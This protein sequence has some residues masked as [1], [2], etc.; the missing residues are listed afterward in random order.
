MQAGF[1]AI[2]SDWCRIAFQRAPA[3]L[4]VCDSATLRVLGANA[5]ASATYGYAPGEWP[6]TDLLSLFEPGDRE[7][8]RAAVAAAAHEGEAQLPALPHIGKDGAC[9]RCQLLCYR[10]DGDQPPPVLLAMQDHTEAEEAQAR[11]AHLQD[12]LWVSQEV[13]GLGCCTMNLTTARLTWSVQQYKNLGLEAASVMPSMERLLAPVHAEERPG[14]AQAIE[15]CI[16]NGAPF[17]TELHLTWPDG[18]EHVMRASGRRIAGD[19]Q[20]PD[21]F[22]CATLDITEQRQLRDRLLQTES[23]LQ[24]AQ[25]IAHIGTWAADLRT[26]LIETTSAETYR[27]F[28]IDPDSSGAPGPFT[29]DQLFRRIHPEDVPGVAAAREHTLHTPG[30][31]YD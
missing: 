24:H 10:L 26:G 1:H 21:W 17:D 8:V 5:C 12:V 18:S 14:F 2:D 25:E 4:V 31:R 30:A 20:S 16:V 11:L 29:L 13:T 15:R 6:D 27:I 22:A 23:D 28:R 7:R 9:L 19:L 3:P